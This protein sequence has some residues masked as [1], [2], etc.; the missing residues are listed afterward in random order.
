[1]RR[2]R[3]TVR[4]RLTLW[5]GGLFLVSGTALLIVT[6]G[7]VEWAF[8]AG[9]VATATCHQPGIG[10]HAI[11]AQQ[12][13]AA[14]LQAH[15]TLLSELWTR[16]A[17]ALGVM[18]VLSIASGWFLAGRALRPVRA[19]TTAAR[20]ISAASLGERLAL[21]GP[22]DELKELGDTFDQLLARLEASFRAQRQFI[23]N[24]AHE[25][26]TPL[27][28]QQVI[29]QVA[30]ADPA[31]SVESLRA[32]HERVLAAGSEQQHIIDALLTLA[33][34]QA[35]LSK[36]EPFDLAAVTSLVLLSRQSDARD[37]GLIVR[38]ALAPAPTAGSQA[39]AERLAAN[40]LDNAL[41]HNVPGG[42]VEI[43]TRTAG[44]QAVLSIVNT[45]PRVPA[46]ALDRLFQP[47]QR[48]TAD[49]TSHSEG[50]GLGLSIVQAIAEAHGA[51]ITALALP[52]GGLLVEV[53]FPDPHFSTASASFQPR[54]PGS[55]SD[56]GRR[57][58]HDRG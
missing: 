4:L 5:Y 6:Y 12:A 29:S 31:A 43:G 21:T 16:S 7:L 47:F 56:H 11:S 53:A 14:V 13:R 19:I 48:M 27:A 10:C 55:V 38:E 17:V 44:R 52:D 37:R 41:R 42:S 54:R 18:T 32:A 45:G 58:T 3:W 39:L 57:S 40:L 24:A 50:I 8:T 25:M 46:A 9:A 51:T 2:P 26:R 28:R 1:M 20:R 30:L 35:G 15:A 36:K 49:R 22:D 33:R 23:A 34:G